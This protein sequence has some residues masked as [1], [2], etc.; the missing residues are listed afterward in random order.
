MLKNPNSKKRKTGID[1]ETNANTD[2]YCTHSLVPY[3]FD[4]GHLR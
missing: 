3:L 4:K 1:N 2:D